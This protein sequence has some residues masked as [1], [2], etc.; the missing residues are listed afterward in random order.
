MQFY[1]LRRASGALIGRVEETRAVKD[2]LEQRRL[3]TLLGPGG[4]GKTALAAEVAHELEPEFERVV[5]VELVSLSAPEHV[6]SEI[7]RALFD[8]ATNDPQALAEALDL[9]PTLL[10]LDNCEHVIDRVAE[11]VASL[12]DGTA[13]LRIL[14]TSRRP[15]DLGEEQTFP[16]RPLATPG[17]GSGAGSVSAH[18]GLG[19]LAP[20]VELFVERVRQAVPSFE[21][22]PR[23]VTLVAQICDAADGVP[24]VVEL[25]A[26]LART[27]PLDEILSTMTEPAALGSTRRDLP[28]HQRTVADS[29]QWSRRFLSPAD[30]ELLNRLSVFVGGFTSEAGAVVAGTGHPVPAQGIAR[31]VDHSLVEFDPRGGRYRLLDVVRL[32]AQAHLGTDERADVEQRHYQWCVTVVDRIEAGRFATDP[33][34]LFPRL[35]AEISNL[36]HAARHRLEHD[37]LDG[38]RRLVGPIAVWWV[39]HAPPDDP[40]QWETA[41]APGEVPLEWQA[42]VVSALAFYWSHRGDHQRALALAQ[43]AVDLHNEVGDH[44]GQALALMGAGNACLSLGATSDAR[45]YYEQALSIAVET[46]AA[47]PQLM[48]HLVLTRIET[49]DEANRRHLHA[50]LRIAEHGFQTAEVLANTE[51]GLL[52]LRRGDGVEARR[53]TEAGLSLARSY[54][55]AESLGTALNGRAEVAAGDGDPASARSLFQE[56][57]AVGRASSHVGLI[58]R[59]EAGLAALP[60]SNTVAGPTAIEAL[61]ER[62][63]AVARLLRGDLTQ[64]EI[65]DE[66]YIAASTVKSHTKSIYRKLGVTKRAHA[67]T[68]AIEL[69]LFDR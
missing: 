68:R 43:L 38:M 10:V 65:G 8:E 34:G 5:A 21:L 30:E 51:L 20:S 24:L 49:D 37:D 63:L 26:A 28:Q 39:H 33:D 47:F 29:L 66:L 2:A 58:D 7:S 55:Y 1:L 18:E 48:A 15:L 6:L 16:L 59:A 69:G 36:C 32:D 62:E 3:V 45:R 50:A 23:T 52:A 19:P 40:A 46:E 67:V 42:N 57:R 13:Q 25:A 9:A 22:T 35:A 61:S 64:R 44:N 54:G 56:A 27:R 4:V 17:R 12:L 60:S 41:F 31:L 14:T 11:V 53:F